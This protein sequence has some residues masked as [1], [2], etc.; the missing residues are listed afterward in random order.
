MKVSDI[1]HGESLRADDLGDKDVTLTIEGWAVKEFD[2]KRKI[3]LRFAESERTLVLNKTNARSIEEML[4]ES[5][6]DHWKGAKITIY[7][8]KTDYGGKRVDCIRV[9][10]ASFPGDGDRNEV[11]F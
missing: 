6:L 3:E 8:T 11:P 4:D 5:D 1:F 9:K 10:A 2:E 7:A